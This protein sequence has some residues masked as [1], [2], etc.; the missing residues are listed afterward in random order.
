M[1]ELD[2]ISNDKTKNW[3]GINKS[4]LPRSFG[5]QLFPSLIPSLEHTLLFK[6]YNIIYLLKLNVYKYLNSYI[7]RFQLVLT[8]F[9]KHIPKNIVI[10]GITIM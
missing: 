6:V 8:I 3:K 9:Q 10:P 5:K 1:S 2:N 4:L 7:H